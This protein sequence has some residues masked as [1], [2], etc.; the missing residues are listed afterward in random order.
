MTIEI[1]IIM[2]YYHFSIMSIEI[3]IPR[4]RCSRLPV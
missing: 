4:V 1:L 3:L 2:F